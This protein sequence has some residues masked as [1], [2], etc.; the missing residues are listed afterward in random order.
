MKVDGQFDFQSEKGKKYSLYLPSNYQLGDNAVLALHP[1]NT[2]RWNSK[3]WRDTLIQFAEEN[4]ILLICPDGGVDGRIDDAIDTAFT[5]TL[6]DSVNR[7][8]GF[9]KSNLV[10]MGF[11]WGGRTV[12]SYGLTHKE[13]FKGLIP[14]GAAIEGIDLNKLSLHSK[15]LNIYI[16]HGS[17]DATA[18]RYTPAIQSLNNKEA[19]LMDTLMSGIGHTIDFPK[20]NKIIG[21][22]YQFTIQN[23]CITTSLNNI[24][25]SKVELFIDNNNSIFF[26]SESQAEFMI[27]NISGQRIGRI[28]LIPGKNQ[29]SLTTGQ[30]ILYS[31]SL[32]QSFKLIVH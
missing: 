20:R 11:S 25:N 22:A 7:W 24:D 12:Y 6:L 13:F 3:S 2:S 28:N 19:C 26:Q 8:Y 23:N 27:S 9:N 17:A 10:A 5:S 4:H 32:R 18:T 30:Y 29:H 14:I 21:D 15:G 31:K 1:F 16:I